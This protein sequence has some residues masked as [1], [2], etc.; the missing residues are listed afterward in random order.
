MGAVPDEIG[1]V[2]PIG[3]VTKG[4]EVVRK[5]LDGPLEGTK[6]KKPVDI[7]RVIRSE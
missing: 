6:L 5:I 7:R 3:R 4:G 2:V 1:D